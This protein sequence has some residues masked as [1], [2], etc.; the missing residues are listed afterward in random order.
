MT[1]RPQTKVPSMTLGERVA[2]AMRQ[3]GLCDAE[4]SICEWIELQPDVDAVLALYNL[5]DACRV[6]FA[7]LPG[8]PPPLR[9]APMPGKSVPATTYLPSIQGFSILVALPGAT[10][11]SIAVDIIDEHVLRVSARGEKDFGAEITVRSA[12]ADI[13]QSTI[14]DGL[15]RIDAVTQGIHLGVE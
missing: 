8:T 7:Q 10:N 1:D 6:A 4:P 5:W 3:Y 15:L 13:A 11:Q 14:K 12:I 9:A 2:Y